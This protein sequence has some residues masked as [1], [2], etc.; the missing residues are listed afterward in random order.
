[1]HSVYVLQA[2]WNLRPFANGLVSLQ[3]AWLAKHKIIVCILSSSPARCR[4]RSTIELYQWILTNYICLW[5][6]L[7]SANIMKLQRIKMCLD[8]PYLHTTIVCWNIFSNTYGWLSKTHHTFEKHVSLQPHVGL[9]IQSA[10]RIQC[11]IHQV[12]TM[13]DIYETIFIYC[14]RTC[15]VYHFKDYRLSSRSS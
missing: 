7:M 14:R 9:T 4:V 3:T 12:F 10:L 6:M 15:F 2:I 13:A 5:A 1:M 11:R 8:H